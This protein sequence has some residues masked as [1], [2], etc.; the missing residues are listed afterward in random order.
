MKSKSSKLKM[1]LQKQPQKPPIFN[2]NK[3]KKLLPYRKHKLILLRIKPDLILQNKMLKTQLT[4]NMMPNSVLYKKEI[5]KQPQLLKKKHLKKLKP[6]HTLKPRLK[7]R[8]DLKKKRNLSKNT[9]DKSPK[10]EQD[11]NRNSEMCGALDP[12]VFRWSP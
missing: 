11:S 7:G 10:K 2:Q 8:Q 1:L 9:K 3:H 4:R 6:Q 12:W 5:I